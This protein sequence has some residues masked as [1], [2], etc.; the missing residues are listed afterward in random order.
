MKLKFQEQDVEFHL[1]LELYGETLNIELKCPGK[2]HFRSW[3][4]HLTWIEF[5]NRNPA[6]SQE[7]LPRLLNVFQ[8]LAAMGKKNEIKSRGN[9]IEDEMIELYFATKPTEFSLEKVEFKFALKSKIIELGS[10]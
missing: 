2:Y 5:A 4:S 6:G 7:I 8:M 1:G 3:Y 10:I 9:F